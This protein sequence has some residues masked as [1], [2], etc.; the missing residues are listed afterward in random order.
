VL[1]FAVVELVVGWYSQSLTL[2]VD[3]LHMGM[4]AGA[5][6]IAVFATWFA[7]RQ[8]SLRHIRRTE[9]VATFINGLGLLAMAGWVLR[10]VISHF[11][12]E[13]REILSWPMLLTALLGL[14]INGANLLWLHDYSQSNLN[15]R[16]IFLHVLADL[17]G[18][19]GAV[20][21]AIAVTLWHLTWIDWVV[22]GAIAL[23]IAT[24]ALGLLW[25]AIKTFQEFSTFASPQPEAL[26]QVGWHEIGAADLS[27]LIT[28]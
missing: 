28:K 10:E 12:G 18:S 20:V 3:S 5:I 7:Q 19:V 15:I 14:L 6:A 8:S 4:D 26:Q 21:V 24:V 13:P 25:Q 11:Q 2:Q 16:S 23:V 1:G 17:L 22:G 27:R 9:L